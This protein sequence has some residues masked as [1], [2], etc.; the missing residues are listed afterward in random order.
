M[1]TVKFDRTRC[2]YLEVGRFLPPRPVGPLLKKHGPGEP[3]IVVEHPDVLGC[4]L[5]INDVERD[6]VIS[7]IAPAKSWTILLD[8]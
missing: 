2:V 6:L 4:E 1:A 8:R 5:G 7:A 3:Q